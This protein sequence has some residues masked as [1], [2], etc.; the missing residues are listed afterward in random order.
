MRK[1]LCILTA[2]DPLANQAIAAQKQLNDCA[3]HLFDLTAGEPDYQK[4]LD[5]IA[6]AD[7]VQVW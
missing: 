5:A 2:A 6:A 3:V 7:S 4:L 1:I